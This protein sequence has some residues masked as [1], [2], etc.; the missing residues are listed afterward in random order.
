ME[1]IDVDY[2]VQE[3]M[4]CAVNVRQQ[5]VN[6][7]DE[8]VYRNALRIELDKHGFQS[9]AEVLYPVLYDGIVVGE[10]KAD[11][12]VEEMLVL[13]LKVQEQLLK[14]HEVQLVNYLTAAGIDD[15]LLINFGSN[16]IQFKRKYRVYRPKSGNS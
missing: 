6:G 10:Y 7:Y 3:V 15:G 5:L 12:V 13:E 1:E 9:E 11:L 2:L 8:K 16:P 4:E 14:T